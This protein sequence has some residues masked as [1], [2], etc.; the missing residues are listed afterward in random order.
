MTR[1]GVLVS[2]IVLVSPRLDGGALVTLFQKGTAV[3]LNG[4]GFPVRFERSGKPLLPSPEA[5]KRA[6]TLSLGKAKYSLDTP[7][8]T[9][10]LDEGRVQYVFAVP[11]RPRITLELTVTLH[12]NAAG[13]SLRRDITIRADEK[14]ASDL[15]VSWPLMPRLGSDTWLPRIDGTGGPLGD[16]PAALYQFAGLAPGDGAHLAIP[17]VSTPLPSSALRATV[18]TDPFF[19]TRFARGAVAWRYPA[20]VGLEGKIEKRSLALVIHEGGP[21]EAIAAFFREALSDVPPGPPWLHEI[22][23]VDYDF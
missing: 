22:A 21:E 15:T 23:M 20:A 8:E 9:R 17:M 13:A 19:S 10:R 3:K 6:G 16:Q 14:L 2:L 7:T 18:L 5:E 11:S 1:L 12:V 4:Q